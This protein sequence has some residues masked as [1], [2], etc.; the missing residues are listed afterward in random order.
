MTTD[1][2]ST[3]PRGRRR[4]PNTQ[5]SILEATRELLLEVGYSQ[6]T[7]E[8]V[9]ARAGAGKATIYRWWPTKGALVLE[10]A[11]ESIS[12]GRVPDTGDTR[13][14]LSIA[15][16]QLISTFSDHL[17]GI[18]IFAVTANLDDDPTMAK[19]F[20]DVFVYPWRMSAAEAIQRGIDR[21]DLPPDTDIQF[22]LDVIV[23]VVFQ[24]TLTLAQPM[25]D[26]LEQAIL[27][28]V[29]PPK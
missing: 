11:E 16:Q 26:G 17:A 12:I 9:A 22:T 23:G 21:G 19:T 28:L 18:V 20:R 29:L 10:A 5:Q 1:T 15:T 7:I 13:Q 4:D 27:K 24:R 25:T 6:I 14:D 8:G 3:S 2:A